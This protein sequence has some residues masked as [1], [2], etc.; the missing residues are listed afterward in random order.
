[1]NPSLNTMSKIVKILVRQ[2]QIVFITHDI[3]KVTHRPRIVKQPIRA[4]PI[5]VP[6][7]AYSGKSDECYYDCMS[8]MMARH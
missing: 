8:M 2:Q 1:M 4:S 5:A 6:H 7:Q 3:R